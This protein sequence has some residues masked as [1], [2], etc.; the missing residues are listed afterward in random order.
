V[1]KEAIVDIQERLDKVYCCTECKAAFL[2][3][4][5]VADHQ[6]IYGHRKKMYEMPF[7]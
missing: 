4:S 3:M 7:E 6:E 1:K 5:D 2:F